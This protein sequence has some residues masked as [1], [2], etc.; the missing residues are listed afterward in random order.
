[1]RKGERSR[2]GVVSEANEDAATRAS[3]TGERGERDE[4][5]E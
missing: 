4:P 2:W 1:V 3:E 5:G